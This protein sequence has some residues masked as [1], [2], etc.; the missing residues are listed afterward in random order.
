MNEIEV[1]AA[2]F[3]DYPILC[4]FDDFLGDRRIDMQRGEILVCDFADE[5]AI[6]YLR[7]SPNHF[8]D[9]PFVVNLCVKKEYRRRGI[10]VAL[11]RAASE[12]PLLPRL[13]IST[14]QSNDPMRKLLNSMDVSEIGFV[15][16]LNIDDERELL[17][18][19]K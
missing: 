8:F 19:L 12:L 6:G 11:L 3:D 4:E 18:R 15:D 13:Y 2:R 5:S 9:W 17:Y 7:I 16:Q 14:E 10:G 1:R